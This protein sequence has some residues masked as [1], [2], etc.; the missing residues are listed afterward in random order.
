[1]SRHSGRPHHSSS[2]AAVANAVGSIQRKENEYKE[3]IGFRR[4]NTSFLAENLAKGGEM[5]KIMMEA[6]EGMEDSI[7]ED[8]KDFLQQ[9]RDR[10]KKL[11][12]QNIEHE[13][14]INAFLSSLDVVRNEV[15]AGQEN[16]GDVR[17]YEQMIVDKMESEKKKQQSTMEDVADTLEYRDLCRNLGEKIRKQPNKGNSGK[18]DG[19]SDSDIEVE[20]K[21]GSN[22]KCPITATWFDEPVKSKQ[23]GHI[24]SHQAILLYIGNSKMKKCP[25]AGCSNATL[26]KAQLE[27]DKVT[28]LKV[29]RE[30]RKEQKEKELRLTQAA[31]FDG[32]DEDEI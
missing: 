22:L 2:A 3:G 18:D 29:A 32:Y 10:L 12:F 7:K 27:E 17:N 11:A 25:V 14:E 6:T 4:S 1:M 5:E 19:D 16:E 28:V 8:I 23:C 9:Q 21:S 13:R 15:S 30:K 24:Y 26:T 31:D 20:K